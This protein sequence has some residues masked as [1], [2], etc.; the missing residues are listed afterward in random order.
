VKVALKL[1]ATLR[2]YFP[3]G[4][5]QTQAIVD[6]PDGATIPDALAI[7]A[8]PLAKAHIV[9]INGRHVLRPDLATRALVDGDQLAVFPAIG[10]G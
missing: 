6:L 8:V 9:M 4:S 5:G 10:G 3:A 2:D 1:Y 7:F